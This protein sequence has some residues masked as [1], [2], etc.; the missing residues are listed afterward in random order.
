VNDQSEFE[1][2]AAL[3]AGCYHS[4]TEPIEWF[5][6]VASCTQCQ[7]FDA[8]M[9]EI[10]H[11]GLVLPEPG[12]RERFIRT[13]RSEGIRLSSIVDQVPSLRGRPLG[14]IFFLGA[15]TATAV[16]VLAV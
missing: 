12:M 2:L 14:R 9:N 4:Q 7:A 16:L 11:H 3:A 10:S 8:T 1:E 15:A 5:M 13:A 6:H